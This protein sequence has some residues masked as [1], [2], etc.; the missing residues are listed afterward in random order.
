[1]LQGNTDGTMAPAYWRGTALAAALFD[2]DGT[3]LDTALDIAL[4]L[5]RTLAEQGW[6]PVASADV[7]LMIG[8]GAPLLIE[9]ALASQRRL[10]EPPVREAL[11]ER[12]FEH[13]GALEETGDCTAE[14]YLGAGEAL[15][16]LHTA[17]LRIAVVTNKQQRF[18]EALLRLRGLRPWVDL[19]IGGDTCPRRKPDPQPLLHACST[20]GVL[21]SQAIMIGDSINDVQAARAAGIPVLCVPYGYN[22]GNDPRALPCDAIVEHLGELP[23]LLR[24]RADGR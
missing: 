5:N 7:R 19:V 4:A 14:P 21:S 11:L 1:M 24:V 12:F 2:L 6:P 13:Y 20:L 8:R 16:A 10:V 15:R 18:A 3:L 9:R 17:G 22:E 23:A